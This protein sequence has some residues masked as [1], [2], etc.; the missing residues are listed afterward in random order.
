[1]LGTFKTERSEMSTHFAL[2]RS[3]GKRP[4]EIFMRVKG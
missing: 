2:K 1:M 4:S 3:E